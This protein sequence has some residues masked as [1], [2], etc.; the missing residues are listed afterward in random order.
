MFLQE[1]NCISFYQSIVVGLNRSDYMV[2]QREEGTFSLKQIE[3]NTISAA[4]FGPSDHLA[5]VHRYP[6][7]C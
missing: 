2:N 7:S 1:L 5:E 6:Q 4:G 3:I